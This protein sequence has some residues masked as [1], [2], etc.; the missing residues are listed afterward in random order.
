MPFNEFCDISQDSFKDMVDKYAVNILLTDEEI[1]HIEY[2]TRGQ[3]Y[4]SLWWEH[5][6]EKFTASN[7]CIAA[8][9][10]V[11]PS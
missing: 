9:S 10:K 3:Q 2:S 4:S 5:R 8:V 6:N 1:K 11:E 7:F